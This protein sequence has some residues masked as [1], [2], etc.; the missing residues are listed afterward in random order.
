M[1]RKL[2]CET[3]RWIVLGFIMMLV[4]SRPAPVVDAGELQDTTV[5][6]GVAQVDITPQTPVRMYGYGA[7]TTL[8]Q[9]GY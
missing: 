6:V 4:V 9:I 3:S 1:L 5:S 2:R 7:R 8:S